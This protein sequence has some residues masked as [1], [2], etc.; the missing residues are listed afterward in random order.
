ML[1]ILLRF[2][3]LK[4]QNGLKRS[5]NLKLIFDGTKFILFNSSKV[6]SAPWIQNHADNSHQT[7]NIIE[8]AHF[9][10]Y[11]DSKAEN[12]FSKLMLKRLPFP[13]G[14]PISPSH[15]NLL[16][17]QRDLGIPHILSNNRTYIAH[18]PGLGKSAQAI[19]AVNTK[20]GRCLI[21]C[22]SFLKTTWVREI[23]K[24]SIK[25][26]PNI[27]VVGD[28][29]SQAKINWQADFVIC[30]DS[31]LIK[32]WVMEAIFK[33]DFRFIFIDEGHR[34]KTADA[35]RTTALFGGKTSKIHSPGLIYKAEHVCV[36]SG[37]P[38]LDKPIELWP[39]LFAMAPELIDFMGYYDFG[40]RYCG[41]FQDDRGH[42]HFTGSTNEAE[43]NQRIMGRF[44]QR[45]RKEDVLKDLP[46]KI[47]EV[48]IVGRDPRT[49]DV[50]FMDKKLLNS[51]ED[52]LEDA[53]FELPQ[54]LGD[55]AKMRHEIGLA[56]VKWVSEF[57]YNLLSNDLDEQIIL[58]A[59][60]RDVV[61]EL[62]KL[63]F[64]FKPLV[65]NGGVPDEIRTSYQD[66]FQN[67]THRL[68]IGNIDAMNLGLTLT[69]ATRV[70]FA[71][72]SWTPAQNEQAEDRAHRIGQKDSVFVQYLVLPNSIDEL[73]LTA[74]LKKED[75]IRK[76]IDQ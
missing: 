22:P 59:H 58:F 24:W 14:G 71:E 49:N 4:K 57:V 28:S 72:Y 54:A 11:A 75:S 46:P 68:I 15:M 33:T 42:W 47:R 44:M 55:Y 9:R 61:D 60:H 5:I 10:K 40:F 74:I 70:V 39:M 67:K 35:S 2:R 73:V 50:I 76:V 26:F 41:S 52:N 7:K 43:L 53:D 12:I 37:T 45:I 51:L 23:T 25:D 38:M 27:A 19:C 31:M 56:K 30:S 63:L 16:P 69:A 32:S 8:A 21:I 1:N 29:G 65:I 6:L 13:V 20:P 48:I 36:L 3:Q 64:I 17:F 66:K 62:K 18:Q 34:F